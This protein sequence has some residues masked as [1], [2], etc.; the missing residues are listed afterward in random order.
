MTDEKDELE[1]FFEGEDHPEISTEV[2]EVEAKVEEE[3][4]Q[5]TETETESETTAEEKPTLV[6]IAALHD[7]RRKA[8]QYKEEN[9]TLRNQIPKTD[10]APD[11]YEDIEAYNA[12][13]RK[14]WD[15]ER[16]E[17]VRRQR[18]ENLDKSRGQMLEQHDDYDEMERIF[19]LMTAADNSLVE[20]MFASGN[21]AKFAYETAKAYKE[22]LLPTAQTETEE[23]EE[24]SITEVPN[25]AKA[26][27]QASNLPQVEK[28]ATIE[29][30][31]ADQEY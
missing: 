9:E 10:E 1:V 17:E 21:E 13:M 12:Y 26:T 8:Q 16:N 14:Q 27:A 28:E 19:E 15:D 20:K 30:V 4:E 7:E 22:S 6:P 31:F 24:T 2:E 25:L 11:P 5:E 29:D 3:S 23:T 18:V